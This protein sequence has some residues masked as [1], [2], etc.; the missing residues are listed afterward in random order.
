MKRPVIAKAF[1]PRRGIVSGV[2]ASIA[3]DNGRMANGTV[4]VAAVPSVSTSVATMRASVCV[5]TNGSS[6]SKTPPYMPLN[7]GVDSAPTNSSTVDAI[8]S[9]STVRESGFAA[10]NVSIAVSTVRMAPEFCSV[11]AGDSVTVGEPA[12]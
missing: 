12:T 5:M 9:M 3:M 2:S 6:H 4:V 8:Q 1:S 7:R 10:K 11:P